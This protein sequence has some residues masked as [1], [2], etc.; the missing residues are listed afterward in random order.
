MR[1]FPDSQLAAG[2]LAQVRIAEGSYPEAVRLL[3]A[4]YR[5]VPSAENLYEWAEALSSSGQAQEAAFQFG[6]FEKQAR[7][8]LLRHK[9][10]VLQLISYYSDRKPDPP[11]ALSLA[12]SEAAE[13]HDS[14]TVAAYA[15]ALYRNGRYSDAKL[16]M[17]KA[18]AVGVRNPVY[19]CH[20][21]LI[22][23][24]A[25]DKAAADRYSKEL[26]GMPGNSCSSNAG[27]RSAIEVKP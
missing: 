24:G 17:E 1:L 14:P 20:A 5:R 15:W 2:V 4:R 6:V 13:R 25:N 12:S 11:E 8:D 9:S 18:L 19:F 21:A 16:Q 7:A 23:T 26:S 27:L 10:G 22:S 3:E